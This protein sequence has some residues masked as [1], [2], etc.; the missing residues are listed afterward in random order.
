MHT[1]HLFE[2]EIDT[3]AN[4]I[5]SGLIMLTNLNIQGNDAISHIQIVVLR[6]GNSPLRPSESPDGLYASMKKSRT[7]GV[8]STS[9]PPANV[10]E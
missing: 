6:L 10:P 2:I 1:I 5:E 7:V 9:S 8:S 4:W 3:T